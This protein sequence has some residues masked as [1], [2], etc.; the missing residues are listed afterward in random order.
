MF[1][2]AGFNP[3]S[4]VVAHAYLQGCGYAMLIRFIPSGDFCWYSSRARSLKW[5]ARPL[6][7]IESGPGPL[8]ACP[9]D[10]DKSDPRWGRT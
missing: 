2:K 4:R 9:V 6:S 8:V 7:S 3:R 1:T 10:A 5:N